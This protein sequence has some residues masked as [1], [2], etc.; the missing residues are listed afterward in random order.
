LAAYWAQAGDAAI[1][2]S[3]SMSRP[4]LRVARERYVAGRQS[5]GCAV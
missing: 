5:S 3:D 4:P 2:P 1:A